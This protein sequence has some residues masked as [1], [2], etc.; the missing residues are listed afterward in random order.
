MWLASFYALTAE[1]FPNNTPVTI[2]PTFYPLD[3]NEGLGAFGY[4]PRPEAEVCYD[5]ESGSF[6]TRE[7]CLSVKDR[8]PLVG[9][10]E[11]NCEMLGGIFKLWDGS[12]E[13]L[14]ESRYEIVDLIEDVNIMVITNGELIGFEYLCLKERS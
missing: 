6:K 9:R 8:R 12:S 1:S 7:L 10:F 3:E 5:A 11:A 2:E 4:Q 13:E 14:D